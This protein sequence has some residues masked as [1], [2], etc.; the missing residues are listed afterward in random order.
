M[1][2]ILQSISSP[3]TGNDQFASYVLRPSS[4]SDSTTSSGNSSASYSISIAE[5]DGTTSAN[6]SAIS[7]SPYPPSASPSNQRN[8]EQREPGIA[9]EA[10][11]ASESSRENI[12]DVASRDYRGVFALFRARRNNRWN[13]DV[14]SSDGRTSAV[15]DH[16]SA[17]NT[18]HIDSEGEENPSVSLS[19]S[20]EDTELYSD[21]SDIT[22]DETSS[23]GSGSS[24]HSVPFGSEYFSSETLPS[25]DEPS[26]TTNDSVVGVGRVINVG[27][28]SS[29]TSYLSHGSNHSS[30]FATVGGS[31]SS[32]TAVAT[33][34]AR[35]FRHVHT[36]VVV[37]D[38]TNGGPQFALRTAINRAIAGAFAGCGEGAVASNIINTT[39]RL[40]WW[41]F[42]R[43]TLPSLESSKFLLNSTFT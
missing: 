6:R 22:V 15:V 21:A 10:R 37:A 5:T 40:Q 14:T 12:T 35:T 8:Q 42:D 23:T 20:A 28:A 4:S 1:N 39:H 24:E 31:Q 11:T 9:N 19:M 43:A 32:G 26:E 7:S 25:S 30:S 17:V 38:G 33:A 3:R 34:T 41:D 2:R 13:V 29:R 36:A 16:D 18:V 27:E